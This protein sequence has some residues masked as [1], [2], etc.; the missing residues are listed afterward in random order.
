MTVVVSAG[1]LALAPDLFVAT[2]SMRI[3]VG[4]IGVRMTVMRVGDELALHSP[5]ALD[6]ATRAAVGETGRVRAARASVDRLLAWDFDRVVVS[7]GDVLEKGGRR[8]IE[9]AFSFL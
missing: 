3:A 9:Q 5:V 4:E 6:A 1:L 7:H 8:A 2:R